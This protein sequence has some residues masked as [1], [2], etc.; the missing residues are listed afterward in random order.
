MSAPSAHRPK[1]N[2]TRNSKQKT[3]EK[4]NAQDP[5]DE[6]KNFSADTKYVEEKKNA[7]IGQID[8]HIRK[9]KNVI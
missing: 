4:T 2:T 8:M 6:K 1:K 5:T 3:E 9:Y 7:D